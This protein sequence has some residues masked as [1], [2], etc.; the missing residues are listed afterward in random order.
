MKS[1]ILFNVD[2]TIST[3]LWPDQTVMGCREEK[4]VLDVKIGLF[5]PI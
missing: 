5:C 4:S 2:N 3:R 1:C